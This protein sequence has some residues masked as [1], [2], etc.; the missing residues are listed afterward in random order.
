MLTTYLQSLVCADSD[1]GKSAC[2]WTAS[3]NWED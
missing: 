3:C 2:V 1:Y